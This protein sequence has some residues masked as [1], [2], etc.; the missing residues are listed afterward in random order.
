MKFYR[1]RDN[2]SA[3]RWAAMLPKTES[4]RL[5]LQDQINNN[6]FWA[7][8]S[9][10]HA[11]M[12]CLDG[13]SDHVKY[14]DIHPAKHNVALDT[15]PWPEGTTI[16]MSSRLNMLLSEYAGPEHRVYPLSVTNYHVS[17]AE[18]QVYYLMHMIDLRYE[19]LWYE[20]TTFFVGDLSGKTS[21]RVFREGEIRSFEDLMRI[22]KEVESEFPDRFVSPVTWR[23]QAPWDFLWDDA[24]DVI[25]SEK[26]KQRIEDEGLIGIA[27]EL[28]KGYDVVTG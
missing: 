11:K 10:I 16:V 21:Y 19:S 26:I 8:P 7:K 25:V 6:R 15:V 23:Y 2:M 18:A 1:I 4:L 5:N 9:I 20:K 28:C 27:F 22:I 24:L 12:V 14:A 13:A 3:V 17:E